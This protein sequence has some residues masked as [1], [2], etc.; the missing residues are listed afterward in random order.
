MFQSTEREG[1]VSNSEMRRWIDSG[2]I[3]ING[4]S[5]KSQDEMPVDILSVVLFPKAKRRSTI[6]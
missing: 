2:A 5:F 1:L 4:L 3:R 6:W